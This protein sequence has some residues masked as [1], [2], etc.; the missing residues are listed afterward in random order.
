MTP[1]FDAHGPFSMCYSHSSIRL[2]HIQVPPSSFS[3]FDPLRVHRLP[4]FDVVQAR[5]PASILLERDLY[6]GIRLEEEVRFG[7]GK[8]L[9]PVTPG[10]VYEQPG[11]VPG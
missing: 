3:L 2:L 9:A 8:Q 6:I 4:I 10:D 7:L 1:A 5:R 11:A